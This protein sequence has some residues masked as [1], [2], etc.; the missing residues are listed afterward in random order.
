MCVQKH[1]RCILL[2]HNWN[3]RKYKRNQKKSVKYGYQYVLFCDLCRHGVYDFF[4]EVK[5][6]WYQERLLCLAK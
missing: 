3:L 1:S 4:S 6:C 5:K 2:I